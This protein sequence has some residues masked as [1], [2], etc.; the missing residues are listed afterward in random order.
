MNRYPAFGTV[1]LLLLSLP[2]ATEAH[3]GTDALTVSIAAT[4]CLG[5]ALIGLA[6]A[7]GYGIKR[8]RERDQLRGELVREQQRHLEEQ[9]R[10]MNELE[11]A[12]QQIREATQHTSA[13]LARI[14]HDL[15]TPM[16]AIIGYTRI[17]QRKAQ[18]ALDAR[19]QRNL[20]NI[21]SSADNLLNLINDILDQFKVEAG[22]IDIK[23]EQ[24]DLE[25][26][27]IDAGEK[28]D[29]SLP[30]ETL[31]APVSSESAPLIAPDREELEALLDSARRGHV[32]D[33][34]ARADKL[35]QMDASL[36]P[37]AGQLRQL[38]QDFKMRELQHFI[39]RFID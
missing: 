20:E 17:L 38:V 32:S 35:E 33:I 19:Q 39:S 30:K 1:A 36:L 11:Q 24:T 34:E 3:S 10:L 37:F 23:P 12:N 27:P 28:K 29:L 15:R 5:L 21:Q 26:P 9:Q 18:D 8:R 16:N 2:S 7:A 6:I 22:R 25:Q 13:F 14:T 4:G 31:A